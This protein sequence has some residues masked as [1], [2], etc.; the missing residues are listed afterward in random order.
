MYGMKPGMSNQQNSNKTKS[1]ESH[2]MHTKY[3]MGDYYGTGVKQKVGRM[4]EDSMNYSSIT[5][6][7]FGKAPK[8]LA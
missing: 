2:C 6:K 5:S 3:G 1:V 4:R 8:S 7:Q